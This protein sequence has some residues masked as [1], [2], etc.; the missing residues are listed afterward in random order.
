MWRQGK[1]N[2]EE[3]AM[4]KPAVEV[5]GRRVYVKTPYGHPVVAKLKELGAKWEPESKS[6][7]V[8]SAKRAAVEALVADSAEAAPPQ[9][10]GPHDVRVLAKVRYKDRT[11]YVRAEGQGRCR[12]TTL[13]LS[14]DFWASQSECDLLKTYQPREER[15]RYGRSTGRMVY[16]TLG[17]IADFVAGQK[18]AEKEGLPACAACG[19]RKDDL[20]RDM[21]DGLMKCYSCC[22]MP[23]E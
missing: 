4:D 3:I 15:G 5:A 6:W 7:W 20:V 19:R 9:K 12:L 11:Y 14:L 10:E 1:D 17:S 18:R 22:D 2:E 21:E 13:D 8:G 23:P 16:T